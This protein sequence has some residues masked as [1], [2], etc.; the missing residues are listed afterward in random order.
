MFL[1]AA[2]IW[3]YSHHWR[4][5]HLMSSIWK[6]V[7]TAWSSWSA[8]NASLQRRG[9]QLQIQTP[10]CNRLLPHYM[11]NLEEYI[12]GVSRPMYSI[13]EGFGWALREHSWSSQTKPGR[14]IR[15]HMAQFAQSCTNKAKIETKKMRC[16]EKTKIYKCEYLPAYLF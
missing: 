3:R 8:P 13:L 11:S 1:C 7:K 14:S 4:H 15:G 10:R 16:V 12:L 2:Q 9:L 5:R 6:T